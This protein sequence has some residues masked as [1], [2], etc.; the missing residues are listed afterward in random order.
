MD[1]GSCFTWGSG[2]GYMIPEDDAANFYTP[3]PILF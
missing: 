2:A 3:K 1:N